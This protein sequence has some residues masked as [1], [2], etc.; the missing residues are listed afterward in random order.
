[1]VLTPPTDGDNIPL[2]GEKGAKKVKSVKG[3]LAPPKRISKLGKLRRM[4]SVDNRSTKDAD[5]KSISA[6]QVEGVEKALLS[7]SKE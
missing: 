1:M 2:A 3:L 7:Q 4:K 6:N 5:R